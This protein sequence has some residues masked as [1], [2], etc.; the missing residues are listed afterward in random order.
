MRK[1]KDYECSKCHN[2]FTT[3]A[4]YG[5]TKCASC[6]NSDNASKHGLYRHRDYKRWES[7]VQRTTNTKAKGYKNYG[8][9]G[10]NIHP[11]WR[12]NVKMFI[13]YISLL[14]NYGEDG[15]TLDRVHN[16]F[17]YEPMNL[18]WATRSEQAINSRARGVSATKGISRCNTKQ[19]WV[20]YVRELGKR[21]QIGQY[22]ELDDAE[23]CLDKYKK[24]KYDGKD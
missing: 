5:A 6:S 19:K 15:Y 24:R 20:V 1:Y 8:G 17:N 3:R 22:I 23:R 13:E 2:T 14:P 11:L 18:R 21:K 7:I 16:D 4:D 12:H 9:R 10:I